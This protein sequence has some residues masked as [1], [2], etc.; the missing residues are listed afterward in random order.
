MD[1]DRGDAVYS[2]LM[3]AVARLAEAL[4]ETRRHHDEI[5]RV[6]DEMLVPVGLQMSYTVDKVERGLAVSNERTSD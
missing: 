1:G 2:A 4:Q 5:R 3:D 6:N